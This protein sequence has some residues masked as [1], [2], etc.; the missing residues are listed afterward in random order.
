MIQPYVVYKN[1]T[2]NAIVLSELKQKITQKHHTGKTPIQRN[3]CFKIEQWWDV[4][5]CLEPGEKSAHQRDRRHREWACLALS[6]SERVGTASAARKDKE[7]PSGDSI[8][9]LQTWC[10]CRVKN[11]QGCM[12]PTLIGPI[13]SVTQRKFTKKGHTLSY[14]RSLNIYLQN[15]G[16]QELFILWSEWN[17]DE[18]RY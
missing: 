11:T 1:L 4:T 15:H 13:S 10:K 12:Y 17:H 5:P 18:T 6:W 2:S 3:S 14:K 16:S 7:Q 9:P 8:S